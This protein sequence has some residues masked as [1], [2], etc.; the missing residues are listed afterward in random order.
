M[1]TKKYKRKE[2]NIRIEIVRN[3]LH[4]KIE[5]N[6]DKKEILRISEELDKLIADYLIE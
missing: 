2:L 4:G 3:L 1:N 5:E 6:A